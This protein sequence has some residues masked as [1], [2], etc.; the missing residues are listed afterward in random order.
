MRESE[1]GKREM[2]WRRI[3]RWS[4][5]IAVVG[6]VASSAVL[7]LAG[8]AQAVSRLAVARGVAFTSYALGDSAAVVCVDE[9]TSTSHSRSKESRTVVDEGVLRSVSGRDGLRLLPLTECR[10]AVREPADSAP[11]TRLRELGT[12]LPAAVVW[13]ERS[14]LSRVRI[15][16]EGGG[17]VGAVYACR[18][19]PVVTR[20]VLVG[21]AP[22]TIS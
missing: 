8:P 21:C 13:F 19:L 16:I 1:R 10:L 22:T 7:A 18:A 20:W 5:S 11:P 4:F 9:R 17:Y 3:I 12:G 6:V 15:G 2:S 14:S